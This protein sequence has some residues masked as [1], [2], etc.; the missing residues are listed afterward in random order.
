[1][2]KYFSALIVL[3]AM[4]E[5]RAARPMVTDDARVVDPKSCQLE[6]WVRM[7]RA[8]T[9]YWMLPGCNFSG[10]VELSAGGARGHND[11][12]TVTSDI[13]YQAKA[14]LRPLV[15]DGWG[16]AATVGT[17][18]HPAIDRRGNLLGDTYVNLPVSMSFRQD[19]QVLH[20]N[21]GWLH[22][23]ASGHER[24]TW[25]VGSETWLGE[26]SQLIAES[27]GQAGHAPYYQTGLRWWLRPQR[28]QVDATAGGQFGEGGDARWLSVGLRLLS[29][30][31]L[32]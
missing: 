4:S 6:S 8:S 32:P 15:A 23:K 9:E 30:P 2:L 29:P 28:V 13:V 3:L 22:D 11:S 12:S 27:Y 24:V 14:L 10:R 20:L 7:N 19:R 26:R 21:A 5:A 17:V 25:G 18:R 31:F 16:L 1:M